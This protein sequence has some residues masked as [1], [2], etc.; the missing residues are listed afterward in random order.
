MPLPAPPSAETLV[1]LSGPI[2]CTE[3]G[4]QCQV[5]DDPVEPGNTVRTVQAGHHRR[6]VHDDC[7]NAAGQN[8][9]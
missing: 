1:D 8:R 7:F 9:L 5:C 3:L 4:S 6:T 2:T